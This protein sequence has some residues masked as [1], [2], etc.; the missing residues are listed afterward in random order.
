VAGNQT[1][2][3]SVAAGLAVFRVR[4]DGKLDFVR[5]YDVEASGSR[6]LFWMGVVALP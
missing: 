6:N 5:K 4:A 2:Y 1:P 3:G